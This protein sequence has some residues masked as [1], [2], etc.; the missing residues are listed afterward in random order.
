[1]VLDHPVQFYCALQVGCQKETECI[2]GWFKP[3]EETIKCDCQSLETLKPL[4][5]LV[6]HCT[7]VPA[8]NLPAKSWLVREKTCV[9]WC[10]AASSHWESNPCRACQCS[11]HIATNIRQVP[12]LTILLYILQVLLNTPVAQHLATTQV[13]AYFCHYPLHI[14]FIYSIAKNY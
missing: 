5:D 13:E 2:C 9:W 11:N 4:I 6:N 14:I 1:M 10:V 8:D 3:F 7:L 12:A